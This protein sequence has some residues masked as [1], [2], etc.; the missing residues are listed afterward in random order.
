MKH[1]TALVIM[2]K[3]PQPGAVKTRLC[4]PLSH[5][6]AADLYRCFLLDTLAKARTLNDVSLILAYTPASSKNFFASLAAD[7]ILMPQQGDGLGNRMAACFAEGF[8]RG[9]RRVLLTGSDL[10]TLPP[11]YLQQ[12]IA[13]IAKPQVDVVLGP[14]EDGGYYLI[15]LRQLHRALFDNMRWSTNTVFAETI[16]RAAASGLRVAYVPRWYD[17]DTASDLKRLQANLSRQ[18]DSACLHTRQ[19]FRNG[20]KSLDP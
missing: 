11:D 9:Y 14:S 12:A 13:L 2:A 15:G 3:A 18:S 4:P 16:Q 7:A 8:D 6:E 17:V 5:P 1:H 20:P 19:F 10:P